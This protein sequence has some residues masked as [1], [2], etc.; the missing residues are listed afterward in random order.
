MF[1]GFPCELVIS[2]QSPRRVEVE[3]QRLR[4]DRRV[5]R[6]TINRLCAEVL[7]KEATGAN[8]V[9]LDFWRRSIAC[10]YSN[11]ITILRDSSITDSM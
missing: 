11:A 1:L 2:S 6:L 8:E 9:A 10:A 7:L 3:I 4:G 5:I